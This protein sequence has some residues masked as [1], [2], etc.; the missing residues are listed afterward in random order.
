MEM[1]PARKKAAAKPAK[2]ASKPKEKAEAPATA[3]DQKQ[4]V[5]DVLEIPVEEVLS[6]RSAEEGLYAVTSFGQ[7]VLLNA[8]GVTVLAGPG[9]PAD[10]ETAEPLPEAEEEPADL[11]A[12]EEDAAPE[13]EGSE[14]E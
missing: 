12:L 3:E 10:V 8:D 4:H 1:A 5:A 6:V 13:S 2:P 7:K 9:S 14:K 11:P